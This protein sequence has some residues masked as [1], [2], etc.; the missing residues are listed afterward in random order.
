MGRA[1]EPPHLY[2]P[3]KPPERGAPEG[4]GGVAKCAGRSKERLPGACD[5][6]NCSERGPGSHPA[7]GAAGRTEGCPSPAH[8]AAG[9]NHS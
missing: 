2:V 9:G 7:P 3:T 5:P 6:G 1:D 8:A 4:M